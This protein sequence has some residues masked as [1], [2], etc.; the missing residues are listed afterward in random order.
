MKT[1]A[2]GSHFNKIAG[3]KACSFIKKRL[4]HRSFPVYIAKFLRTPFFTE[5]LRGC[6]SIYHN[7]IVKTMVHIERNMK[8]D[9]L[10]DDAS[11]PPIKSIKYINVM[12]TYKRN[13]V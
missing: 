6:F 3:L 11:L 13:K 7:I 9:D 4:Q 8:L 12:V 10:I 5:H 2:L 1:T